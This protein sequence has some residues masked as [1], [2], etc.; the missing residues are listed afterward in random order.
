MTCATRFVRIAAPLLCALP[1]ATSASA[2]CAWVLWQ[3]QSSS[4]TKGAITEPVRAYS[5]KQD[6]DQGIADALAT[7]SGPNVI[8]K[9]TKLQEV[10]AML[11]NQVMSYAYVC[12]PDTVDP[13]G[14]KG[15]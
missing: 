2:E 9:D 15:K 13:R 3:S 4:K 1:L 5:T 11:G 8:N 6:C 7:F 12:L 10:H 14:P